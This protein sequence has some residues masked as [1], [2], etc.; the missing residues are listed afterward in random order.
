MWVLARVPQ[1]PERGRAAPWSRGLLIVTRP[2]PVGLGLSWGCLAA[3]AAV[4]EDAAL[5][6]GAGRV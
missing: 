5:F 4:F 1:V 6:R 2:G 3:A